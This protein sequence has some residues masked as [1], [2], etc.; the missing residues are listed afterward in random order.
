MEGESYKIPIDGEWTLEDLYT[1]PRTYEQCY[2]LYYALNPDNW[3]HDTE[4]IDYAYGAYPWQ[5]GYS[6]VNFYN[7]LKWAVPPRYRP[8]IIS[9][10][11]A[12]PGWLELFLVQIVARSLERTVK[13]V[14]NSINTFNDT[15]NKVYKDLQ[16]RKLLKVK[17]EHEIRGLNKEDQSICESH[18]REIGKILGIDADEIIKHTDSPLKAL[19]ILLSLYRRVRILAKF[20]KQEKIT[21]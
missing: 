16:G 18:V 10:R 6:A 20:Q 5:G 1:F 8:R 11:Y 3:I 14:C 15:Y 7:Q 13:S 2:F 19:K 9:I 21:L 12:S 17:T 4:R